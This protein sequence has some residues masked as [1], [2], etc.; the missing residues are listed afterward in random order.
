MYALIA[1]LIIVF[2][3]LSSD[4]V[5]PNDFILVEDI[6]SSRMGERNMSCRVIRDPDTIMQIFDIMVEERS[7]LW[8]ARVSPHFCG[9]N[10][11][12]KYCRGNIV[13]YTMSINT[14]CDDSSLTSKLKAYLP[15]K[16]NVQY[17]Q[18][19]VVDS[20]Q[21][22]SLAD[23]LEN[24]GLYLL[25][26]YDRFEYKKLSL[27]FKVGSVGRT[28]YRFLKNYI[29]NNE[30]HAKFIHEYPQYL[31]FTGD[32]QNLKKQLLATF[33]DEIEHIQITT[34][35]RIV[36]RVV[37]RNAERSKSASK[38]TASHTHFWPSKWY[39]YL[40][41][42]ENRFISF[43]DS[44]F[45]DYDVVVGMRL[46][47]AVQCFTQPLSV[48]DSLYP[49]SLTTG[50][51]ILNRYRDDYTDFVESNNR[52]Y[53]NQKESMDTLL[54]FVTRYANFNDIR[55]NDKA[56]AVLQE[57]AQ[58]VLGAFHWENEIPPRDEWIFD[59]DLKARHQKNI[60]KNKANSTSQN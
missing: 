6:S 12:F 57:K 34:M 36:V 50:T 7:P 42:S 21:L 52:I 27:F 46:M 55:A 22:Q 26:E 9:D 18:F 45:Q 3:A 54:Y 15:R 28:Y 16:N 14:R 44:G 51:E 1:T 33:N 11:N 13:L 47:W 41:R 10:Y 20:S 23:S 5:T 38:I 31:Y 2:S 17:L 60:A 56:F 8:G 40:M 39:S 48:V 53:P 24:N 49:D 58:S 43:V 37:G 59:P 29:E 4:F 32:A 35:K 30:P 19:K 25:N